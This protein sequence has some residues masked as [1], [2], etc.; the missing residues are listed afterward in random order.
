MTTL[1]RWKLACA[2]FA[3]SPARYRARARAA[4]DNIPPRPRRRSSRGAA[5]ARA[6]PADPRQRRGRSACR[7][8]S[9]STA[10]WRAQSRQGRPAARREARRG[11]RRRR[12]DTLSP[13]LDDPRRG[14]PEAMLGAFGQIGT[15]HAVDV[16]VAH[17][18]DDRPT[19]RNAAI[20]ALGSTQSAQRREA[21]LEIVAEA[22]AIPRRATAIVGARHD[23]HATARSRALIELGDRAA[24]TTVASDGGLRARRSL[25]R[26]RAKPRCAS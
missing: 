3:A 22:A 13:L 19:V 6:A 4:A 16:L 14:V 11:R 21:L 1:T 12:V 5:A 10:S 20:G 17:T 15:E 9:W 24:T 18:K 7:S 25:D 23:R 2:L 26:R 8:T